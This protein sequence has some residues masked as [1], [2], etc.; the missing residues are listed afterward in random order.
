LVV[1]NG[2]YKPCKPLLS[3][4]KTQQEANMNVQSPLIYLWMAVFTIK[5]IHMRIE[6]ILDRRF[7]LQHTGLHYKPVC[8][9]A[10]ME[11]HN[12]T[13]IEARS[14]RYWTVDGIPEMVMGAIWI[15]WG[16]GFLVQNTIPKGSRLAEIYSWI[17]IAL[18][19]VFGFAA[20]WIIKAL[21][22]KYTFPRGGYVKFSDP[23]KLQWWMTAIAAGLVA[24]AI[25]LIGALVV[26]GRFDVNLIA[27]ASGLILAI[28]FL[29]GS[30]MP[31]MRHL[32]WFSFLS[33]VMGAVFYLLKL[34]WSA[35]PWLFTGLGVLFMVSGFCRLRAYLR[36]VPIQGGD[37]S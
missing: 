27:P 13:E 10:T 14:K 34:G 18:M 28:G 1:G 4:A 30:R 12:L 17:I 16:V 3:S 21:K 23:P 22:N 37:E 8:M 25:S 5:V 35:L 29:F 36:S 11:Y 2:D 26:K 7:F 33:L 32:A 31:G 20:N 15:I 24:V 19:L 9:E 6:N